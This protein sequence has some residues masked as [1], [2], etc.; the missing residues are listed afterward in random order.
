VRAAVVQLGVER[1]LDERPRRIVRA[2]ARRLEAL[3]V[4][5]ENDVGHGSRTS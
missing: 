4:G 3:V 2:P 1:K 5:T